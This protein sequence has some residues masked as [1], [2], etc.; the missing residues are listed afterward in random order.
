MGLLAEVVDLAVG[1]DCES[2]ASGLG[3]GFGF[4]A[5]AVLVAGLGAEDVCLV[6][7]AAAMPCANRSVTEFFALDD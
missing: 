3:A 5:L 7:A 4:G 6:C 2:S 1:L